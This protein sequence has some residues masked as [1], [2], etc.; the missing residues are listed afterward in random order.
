MPRYS[1]PVSYIWQ[2]LQSAH[3]QTVFLRNISEAQ[4][5]DIQQFAKTAQAEHI[6]P[7]AFQDIANAE[8][9]QHLIYGLWQE[10]HA[11]TKRGEKT[12]GG[13]GDALNWVGRKISSPLTGAWNFAKNAHHYFTHDNTI[14][15]HTRLTAKMIAET[16]NADISE[17]EDRLGDYERVENMSTDWADV[18]LNNETKQIT[19]SVR[20]SRD[21]EDF[22]VDDARILGGLGPRDLV[23][24]EIKDVFA[25]YGDDYDISCAGHSLGGSLV[26]LALEKNDDLDPSQILFFNPGTAPLP[27]MQDAVKH[28]STD[29]RAYY[30]INAIDPVSIG[31]LSETPTHLIMNS[32]VSWI[33]PVL[34]HTL[35]QWI[36]QGRDPDSE[37]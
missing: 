13:L 17:R 9:R 31:E 33:N 26:A 10:H 14:S 37:E 35:G 32:P 27:M 11:R 30:Y 5:Q 34:N 16:Y 23:S 8:S 20:G 2:P 1:A 12:G 18:W 24:S 29:D 4:F 36:N 19:I 3:R 25:K 21:K 6:H 28:F 7:G 15:E 22:L